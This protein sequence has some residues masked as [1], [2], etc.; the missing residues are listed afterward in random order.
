M[1]AT[2]SVEVHSDLD[3]LPED[4]Q[5]LFEHAERANLEFGLAWYKTLVANVFA[6]R[7]HARF[8][9]LRHDG[10]PVAVIPVAEESRLGIRRVLAL[11]NFYTALYAPLIEPGL[12]P[13][14]LVPVI[15][16]IHGGW[17]GASSLKFWPMD[18]DAAS[19][20]VLRSALQLAGLPTF[21]Y[22]CFGSWYLP[23]ADRGWSRYLESR[24]AGLRSTIK[25]LG[26]KFATDGG[27]FEILSSADRLPDGIAAFE[28]VYLARW[29]RPE[30]FPQFLPDLIRVCAER[31]WLR[32]GLSWLND[33]PVAA[34]LWLVSSGRVEIYKVAYD[35]AF[36]QYSP[37][38]LLTA[39]L[40]QHV[41]E[42][43]G[44]SE[45]DY[46]IGD[47]VY[48]Q[49][50]MSHRRERWGL[51]AYNPFTVSGLLGCV[52]E[53]LGRSLKPVILRVQARLRKTP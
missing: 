3:E 53:M 48:K 38:T 52:R 36:K 41:I 15:K 34:Q 17:L 23:D 14:D 44:A 32:L 19:Y 47:D 30:P 33:K 51:V 22:F 10:E 18:P 50:W 27:R 21:S 5:R 29:K 45:V 20:T 8:F 43:D 13:A 4:V 31:G 35:D 42:Q 6:G 2:V 16:A 37:G 26:K 11:S 9:V 39:H 40:L 49:T 7:L 46:L 12:Q 25:R 1:T 24:S 28:A